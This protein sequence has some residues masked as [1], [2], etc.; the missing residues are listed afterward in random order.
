MPVSLRF[1][2]HSSLQDID[3]LFHFVKLLERDPSSLPPHFGTL[4]AREALHPLTSWAA[5]HGM[6][7]GNPLSGGVRV[8]ASALQRLAVAVLQGG[9]DLL[10]VRRQTGR[11]AKISV[12]CTAMM[13]LALFLGGTIGGDVF[14]RHTQGVIHSLAEALQASGAEAQGGRLASQLSDML[15]AFEA[16]GE[17]LLYPSMP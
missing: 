9:H 14:Y 5:D 8:D 4:A 1:E 17:L 3:F 12:L 2:T 6:L 10:E 11:P 16:G 13:R 7:L 15:M